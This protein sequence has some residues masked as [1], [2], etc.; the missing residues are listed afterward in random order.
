MS[1]TLPTLEDACNTIKQEYAVLGLRISNRKAKAMAL[2]IGYLRQ[3]AERYDAECAEDGED[4]DYDRLHTDS[5]GEGCIRSA[6][7]AEARRLA[8]EA[9][10]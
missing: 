1:A 8:R 7:R 5:I 6:I 9:A 2:E 3:V 4:A 10:A